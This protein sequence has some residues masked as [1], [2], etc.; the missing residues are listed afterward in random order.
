MCDHCNA[1]E[2]AEML[3]DKLDEHDFG[4]V[5]PFMEDVLGFVQDNDHVTEDQR[6]GVQNCIDAQE[7]RRRAGRW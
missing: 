5:R 7:K 3:E 1:A 2:F 4:Q 6:R